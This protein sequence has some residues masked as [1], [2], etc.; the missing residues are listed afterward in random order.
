MPQFSF[1]VIRWKCF[2]FCLLSSSR[3][4]K[5][6]F[7]E[8]SHD[9]KKLL[10]T[11]IQLHCTKVCMDEA[12]TEEDN[13]TN[14]SPSACGTF[15]CFFFERQET[16]KC[17]N[18]LLIHAMFKLSSLQRLNKT[19]AFPLWSFNIRNNITSIKNNTFTVSAYI[20]FIHI[21]FNFFKFCFGCDF[22]YF[23]ICSIHTWVSGW[24][25]LSQSVGNVPLFVQP[26]INASPWRTIGTKINNRRSVQKYPRQNSR[27]RSNK[28]E[29][30]NLSNNEMTDK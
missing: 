6:T 2:V 26:T 25:V 14:Q 28:K 3:T 23:T 22:F 1:S 8:Q 30:K 9:R 16:V 18:I 20:L 13:R 15:F 17:K 29:K 19:Q 10:C 27:Y 21:I 24:S 5:C 7:W 12:K 11:K 4:T